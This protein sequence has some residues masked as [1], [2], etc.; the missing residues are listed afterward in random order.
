MKMKKII[1]P[2]TRKKVK[3]FFCASRMFDGCGCGTI[4]ET[5]VYLEKRASRPMC[6]LVS[7]TIEHHSHKAQEYLKEFIER[8]K[9]E[10]RR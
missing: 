8:H 7:P 2:G 9:P 10:R 6:T 3:T 4:W 1:Y 5:D